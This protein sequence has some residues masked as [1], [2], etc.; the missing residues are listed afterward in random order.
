MS[1][2]P[3][4]MS[5]SS[6]AEIYQRIVS[7]IRDHRLTPGTKLVE[8]K[9]GTLF[10]VSR[11]RI[12]PV[13]VRLA[14]ERIVTLTPHRGAHVAEPDELESREVFEVRRLIEPTL[15]ARFLARATP[16][17]MQRLQDSID[18]EEDARARGDQQRAIRVAGDFHL[19]I[20]DYAGH[21]T[22]GRILRELVSRTSLIL[23]RWGPPPASA[24]WNCGC[25]DHRG[26]LACLRLRDADRAAALMQAHL[27]QLETQLSF[28]R[29]E[30]GTDLAAMLSREAL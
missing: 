5:A 2:A 29:P 1:A 9:L 11:T 3:V 28:E 18:E 8:D 27:L 12:R 21:D 7:A 23:M 13:L 22:L 30:A 15:L 10:G 19:L 14:N 16:A 24:S 20:S 6:D 25:R 17:D 4:T 26:L